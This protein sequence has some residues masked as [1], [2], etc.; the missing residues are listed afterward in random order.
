[1]PRRQASQATENPSANT[2]VDREEQPSQQ[3]TLANTTFKI[4][5]V[6]GL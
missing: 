6:F 5:L 1:M 4:R 3:P 2:D